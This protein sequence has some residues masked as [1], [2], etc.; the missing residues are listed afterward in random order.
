MA[1][2]EAAETSSF[3]SEEPESRGPRRAARR[4]HPAHP[5]TPAFDL[6]SSEQL[7]EGAGW[8]GPGGEA[9][10]VP[11][12]LARQGGGGG[13]GPGAG[14]GGVAVPKNQ[15]KQQMSRERDVRRMPGWRDRLL[16]RNMQVPA[17]RRQIT[18]KED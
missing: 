4:A 6:S 17:A 7:A 5:H 8:G 15:Q 10:W 13:A 18:L 11:P 3:T 16:P 2:R 14:G 9:S 12:Q 1:P